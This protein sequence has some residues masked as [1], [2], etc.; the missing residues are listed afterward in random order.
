MNS[1][2]Q[3]S[4]SLHTTHEQTTLFCSRDCISQLPPTNKLPPRY[5]WRATHIYFLVA[6]HIGNYGLLFLS[7]H[8]RT[9]AEGKPRPGHGIL[10]GEGKEPELAEKHTLAFNASAQ[11]QG[12]SCLL[13]RHWPKYVTCPKSVD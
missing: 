5:Q 6:S 2:L 10:M 1:P 9:Q 13:P 7:S 12:K 11:T 3:V 8:S 4:R